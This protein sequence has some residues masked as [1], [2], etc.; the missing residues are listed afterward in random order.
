MQGGI[1]LAAEQIQNP[2]ELRAAVKHLH[3]THAGERKEPGGSSASLGASVAPSS[4]SL[5]ASA[6]NV[7]SAAS[8]GAAAAC[9]DSPRVEAAQRWVGGRGRMQ[10]A[11]ISAGGPSSKR[12][13]LSRPPTSSPPCLPHFP[14]FTALPRS[15]VESL[16]RTVAQLKA[17]LEAEKKAAA[18][19]QRRMVQQNAAL[20]QRIRELQ[21]A[22][23]GR[24]GSRACVGSGCP[25]RGSPSRGLASSPSCAS[26]GGC[27]GKG[28]GA[29]GGCGGS[30]RPSR[31]PSACQPGSGAAS[32]GACSS[33]GS[34][35]FYL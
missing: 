24:G 7:A 10:C 2:E 14:P 25:S 6:T 33:R 1:Q 35:L 31:S 15:R 27:E 32:T 18:V 9:V 19:N 13:V 26:K 22:E 3:K 21:H 17:S 11:S 28:A 4:A 30:G 23:Q 5:G 20:V 8:G 29:E 34:E 16:E 12:A